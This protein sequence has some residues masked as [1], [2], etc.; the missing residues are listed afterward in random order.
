MTGKIIPTGDVDPSVQRIARFQSLQAGQ[1]WRA[2]RDV[3]CEGIAAETVLLIMSIRCVDEV[4]HTVILRP[5]PLQINRA[6]QLTWVGDDGVEHDKYHQFKE[7]RFLLKDFLDSFSFEPDHEAIRSAELGL[8]NAKIQGLQE[9]I[10]SVHSNPTLMNQVVAE[11]LKNAQEPSDALKASN[12]ALAFTVDTSEVAANPSAVST[13]HPYPV[14]LPTVDPEV[15]SMATGTLANAI[16]CGITES[17][18]EAMK[19]AAGHELQVATIKANWIQAKTARIAEELSKLAPF[20]EEKGAQA[21]AQTEEVRS[22][23]KG[24]VDGIASLDLYLGT[25]VLVHTIKEG[26]GADRGIPLSVVQGKR[27]VEHELA[28]YVDLDEWFDFEDQ[29]LFFDALR[30]ETAF[31]DQFF[32]TERCVLVAVT[33]ARHIDY[34]E[35]YVNIA[36]N[37]EN[38][39]VYLMVR[40]G[41]NIHCVVSPVESHLA[42][43]RLF[44]STDEQD[45]IFR[46]MDGSKIRFE[47]V[48]YTDKLRNH[49]LNALHYRRFLILAAGLDHRLK[50]FGDFHDEGESLG[51]VSQRFQDRWMRFLH[52]DDARMMLA[53]GPKPP[54][55]HE[56]ISQKNA[57]LRPGS[58]VLC[59]WDDLINP[60][61]APSLAKENYRS[62]GCGYD[63]RANPIQ[64]M[65]CLIA[66]K[67]AEHVCVD[68]RV[69]T[70]S[71]HSG[72]EYTS[73]VRVSS[74]KRG[75]WDSAQLPFL[76]LD[77]VDP[78]ELYWFIHHRNTRTNHLEYLRFFKR[79]LKLIETERSLEAPIR[80]ALAQ[81]LSEGNVGAAEEREA[82]V[83]RAIKA[84]RAAH[85]GQPL[86][87]PEATNNAEWRR[88]LDQMFAL[89]VDGSSKAV[90]A[91]AFVR[92]LGYE[93]LR[94]V[95]SGKAKF[96]IYAAPNE[97][98]RDD[99]LEP[100]AWVHRITLERKKTKLVE[101]SR[102]WE[103]L[104]EKAAA[105]TVLHEWAGAKYWQLGSAFRTLAR[106]TEILRRTETFREAV[107]TFLKGH[108][109]VDAVQVL[110]E[111]EAAF[112]ASSGLSATQ[113]YYPI[114]A[115]PIAVC[116]PKKGKGDIQYLCLAN[117]QPHRL[118]GA[119]IKD[120]APEAFQACSDRFRRVYGYQRW[121]A[122]MW[123]ESRDARGDW[124]LAEVSA[125]AFSGPTGGY[126]K[127]EFIKSVSTA[128]RQPL[129]LLMADWFE[130]WKKDSLR[131][132][133]VWSPT[134][135]LD[136]EGG[137]LVDEIMGFKQAENFAPH[138]ALHVKYSS[139]GRRATVTASNFLEWYDLAPAGIDF[140]DYDLEL[141][142]SGYGKSHYGH[143]YLNREDALGKLRSSVKGAVLSDSREHPEAPQPP[144]G[145]ERLYVLRTPA[146][147]SSKHLGSH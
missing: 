67:K 4:P 130:E 112:V 53:G 101:V 124:T 42:A 128:S 96:A 14:A 11:G 16:E 122:S 107:A 24:I 95:L 38:A 51:F 26:K 1:Y 65:E 132:Y 33:T 91:E 94:L 131:Y 35:P 5:H 87:S 69:C 98:E 83:S 97:E 119:L 81:A 115:F 141:F 77:A 57:Y 64:D 6:R 41:E 3:A 106:K 13:E 49:E 80:A 52:D 55:L 113:V 39:K 74:Y 84:W 37:R 111:F 135:L 18:V 105:E 75:E 50:L 7:H 127:T 82:L 10:T 146:A 79:A 22:Y 17:K 44:P 61:T 27:I 114:L 73:T 109:P 9:E 66:Y 46:G 137:L 116:F 62:I 45:Q 147:E 104:P 68:V 30:K 72:R 29:H 118:L 89:S 85:R 31:V 8:I 15:S 19:L 144:A 32:P 40:N 123:S 99:R 25:N 142:G 28:V 76:V 108:Q 125:D 59:H 86:P 143:T 133:K 54:D 136:S 100:H 145:I 129:S 43:A 110:R 92:D 60:T 63:L 2:I 47:D 126:V 78:E 140:P 139:F 134:D 48:A 138:Q 23:V 36:R 121:I 102:R 70:N 21:L 93:P 56:W 117:R 20:F 103:L 34:G 90:E 71:F 58:R 120:H 12:K 88:L